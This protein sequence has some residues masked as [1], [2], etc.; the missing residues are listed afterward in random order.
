MDTTKEQKIDL[1]RCKLLRIPYR[2]VLDSIKPI[3]RGPDG[4]IHVVEPFGLPSGTIV[5][6]VVENYEY[7]AFDFLLVHEDFDMVEEGAC[8]RH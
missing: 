4:I 1:R 8:G 2:V 6:K 3:H 5:K 7:Q